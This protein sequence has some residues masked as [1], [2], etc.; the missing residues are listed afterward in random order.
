[1]SE[2][3]TQSRPR[4]SVV[5]P[6]YNRMDS[7]ADTLRGLAAQTMV[8]DSF[9]VLVIDNASTDGTLAQV[10][11]MIPAM[12]YALRVK[13][14]RG[15][16]CGP[17]P[18]R[19][20]GVE[21]AVGQVIAF[22]DSDCRPHPQWLKAG[23]AAFDDPEVA[24]ATGVV[25]FKPEQV[26]QLG[27]FARHTVVSSYE[28]PTYPTANAFYRTDIFARF[29]GFDETLSFPSIFGIAVE[30][31]DTDLA[32]RIKEAG[33][34]NVF[35]P[36]AIV[37]HEVQLISPKNWLLEPLR[38][39]LV[40]ALV[41]LHPG[42]RKTLLAHGLFFYGGSIAYYLALLAFMAVGILNPS[43]LLVLP[44]LLIGLAAVKSRSLRPIAV[45]MRAGQIVMNATRIYVMS[46][47]LICGSL[48]SR[49]LVL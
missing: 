28:H 49:V 41:K 29:G 26:H 32:W 30:A 46:F 16:N 3:P 18:A 39:F 22:T 37:H 4:I 14:I 2:R 33:H 10:E 45:L 20:F 9:E 44:V 43:L 27:F 17:A 40:P 11:A 24:F 23:L 25:D 15:E 48:R 35:V 47:A 12:P 42:L 38:L 34:R 19:N 7:L 13:R 1:M 21:L 31:A 8:A 5:I 6:S 36:T